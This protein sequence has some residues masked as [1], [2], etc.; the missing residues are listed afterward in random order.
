MS[1]MQKIEE[2]VNSSKNMG[3]TIKVIAKQFNMSEDDAARI[4]TRIIVLDAFNGWVDDLS[5]RADV[6]RDDTIRVLGLI[7]GQK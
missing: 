3:E 4:A 6:S 1:N 7:L 2:M 5:N